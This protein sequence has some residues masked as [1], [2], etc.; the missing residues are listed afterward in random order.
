MKLRLANVIPYR[1]IRSIYSYEMIYSLMHGRRKH[2]WIIAAPKSGS[3]WLNYLLKNLLDWPSQ[4]LVPAGGRREREIDP[5]MLMQKPLT[6]SLFSPSS[7]THYSEATVDFIKRANISC[8]FLYR[9]IFDQLVSTFDHCENPKENLNGCSVFLERK[10]YEKLT[11]D[12]KWSMLIDLAAPWYLKQMVG[13]LHY[14]QNN[15][16]PFFFSCSYNELRSDPRM[17]LMRIIRWLGVERS[18]E[19][20]E[21]VLYQSRHSYTRK[22]VGTVGRGK[23]L[24]AEQIRRVAN[25]A[26]YYP[27]I[28]LSP[29]GITEEIRQNPQAYFDADE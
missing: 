24:T 22:N 3:T 10:V 25:Y 4:P 14:L 16:P 2:V 29:I 18:N 20:I 27:G 21:S 9:N 26:N 5:T 15:D 17:L 28:D 19:K 23:N 6:R 13:W 7:H 8:V 12:Q 11:T 1:V